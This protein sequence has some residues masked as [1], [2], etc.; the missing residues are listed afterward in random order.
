MLQRASP[1]VVVT[2]SGSV[3]RLVGAISRNDMANFTSKEDILPV[4]GDILKKFKYG[5]PRDWD[6]LVRQVVTE[7]EMDV[8][9]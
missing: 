3:Y 2:S 7:I 8:H 6:V 4:P 9:E 1:S 5:F